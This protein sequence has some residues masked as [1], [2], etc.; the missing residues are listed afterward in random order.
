MAHTSFRGATECYSRIIL[1]IELLKV[2]SKQESIKEN[3]YTLVL[4]RK[5]TKEPVYPFLEAVPILCVLSLEDKCSEEVGLKA[6]PG[7]WQRDFGTSS[8]LVTQPL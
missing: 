8:S 4:L 6:N 3:A 1:S 7:R 2:Y 5:Q